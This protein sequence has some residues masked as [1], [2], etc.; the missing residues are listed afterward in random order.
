MFLEQQIGILEWFLK[1][2][3]TLKTGV[4]MLKIQLCIT[5]INY[6]LK[7]IHVENT[8]FKLNNISQFYS[9][10][11]QPQQSIGAAYCTDSGPWQATSLWACTSS[12]P[13]SE[14]FIAVSRGCHLQLSDGAIWLDVSF[15]STVVTDSFFLVHHTLNLQNLFWHY[16]EHLTPKSHP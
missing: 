13:P 1:D 4:M 11:D 12:R 2:H 3:V 9:I 15:L 16:W 8:S 14:L 5:G 6:I 10:F 7:Y